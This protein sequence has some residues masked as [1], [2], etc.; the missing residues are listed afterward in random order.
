MGSGNSAFLSGSSVNGGPVF[1]AVGKLR[2]PHGVQGE[3]VT[4]VLTDFPELLQPGSVVYVGSEH[5]PLEIHTFRWHQQDALISFREFLNRDAAG[6]LRN[7]M[8]F[9]LAEDCPE[10]P[11]GEY[12]F[13]QVV[14]MD[15][16]TE[17]GEHLGIV[18]EIHETGAND[19]YIVQRQQK[20]DLLLPATEEVILKIDMEARKMT[21]R[22][23]PGLIDL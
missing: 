11:E 18:S 1:I 3:I 21:V 2:R 22:L 20:K 5:N 13:H 8:L 7:Q 19:V 9:V 12:Y 10:L 16:V 4:S 14:G 23:L 17:E 15:V 6:T